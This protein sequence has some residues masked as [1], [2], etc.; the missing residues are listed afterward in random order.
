MY[1]KLVKC[2]VYHIKL[3]KCKSVYKAGEVQGVSYK[4]REMQECI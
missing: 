1:I 4:A 2:R 3:G